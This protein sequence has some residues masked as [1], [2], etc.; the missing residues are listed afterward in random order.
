MYIFIG[1]EQREKRVAEI[2][3]EWPPFCNSFLWVPSKWGRLIRQVAS[4]KKWVCTNRDCISCPYS[5]F[6]FKNQMKFIADYFIIR[7]NMECVSNQLLRM[8]SFVFVSNFR[9]VWNSVS[10]VGAGIVGV[11][12]KWKQRRVFLKHLFPDSITDN[13]G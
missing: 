2:W 8:G 13:N 3:G 7:M 4:L 1:S 5:L 10:K 6:I 11:T 9:F 12:L